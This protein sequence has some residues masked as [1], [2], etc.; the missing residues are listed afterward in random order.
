[1]NIIIDTG[2]KS[3]SLSNRQATRKELNFLENNKKIRKFIK[4]LSDFSTFGKYYNLDYVFQNAKDPIQGFNKFETAL[5]IKNNINII[6]N[7][8]P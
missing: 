1:M 3:K 5:A 7:E 6:G 8:D 4:V 2:N